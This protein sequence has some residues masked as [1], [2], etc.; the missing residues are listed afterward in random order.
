MLLI[1]STIARQAKAWP[2]HFDRRFMRQA[3][4][5]QIHIA[6]QYRRLLTL[7]QIKHTCREVAHTPTTA[8]TGE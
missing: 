1:N 7:S 5:K 4:G 8:G 3:D 6:G 2:Y